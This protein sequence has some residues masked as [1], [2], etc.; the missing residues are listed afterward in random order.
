M[1][2]HWLI[3]WRNLT[4]RPGRSLAVAAG[5]MIGVALYMTVHMI[6]WGID[7]KAVQLN[8]GEYGEAAAAVLSGLR[9]GDGPGTVPPAVLEHVQGQAGVR[10][11]APRI[12]VHGHAAVVGGLADV[13]VA[14]ADL[15]KEMQLGNLRLTSGRLPE[16]GE[17]AVTVP[18][19]MKYGVKV[20]DGLPIILNGGRRV[21]AL[22]TGVVSDEGLGVINQGSVVV[23]HLN[24]A[25]AW[26]LGDRPTEVVVASETAA[27]RS[28][29]FEQLAL[30]L[31]KQV[32]VRLPVPSTRYWGAAFSQLMGLV[33]GLGLLVGGV[34]TYNA[35]ALTW[36]QRRQ[37][38]ALV[39]AVG[40]TPR[41]VTVQLAL[42]ALLLG[43]FASIPGVGAG[44]LLGKAALYTWVSRI[45]SM[46]LVLETLPFPWRGMV[47]ALL[48]GAVT[49]MLSG[50]V[51]ALNLSR[52]SVVSALTGGPEAQTSFAKSSVYGLAAALLGLAGAVRLPAP[53]SALCVI[54]FLLGLIPGFATMVPVV[55]G[56]ARRLSPLR[57]GAPAWIALRNLER[58]PRQAAN[59]GAALMAAIS[60]VVAYSGITHSV[61][62]A[63]DGQVRRLAGVHLVLTGDLPPTTIQTIRQMPGVGR[64]L[65]LSSLQVGANGEGGLTALAIDPVEQA[66]V[67]PM[68][69]TAGDSNSALEAM[70]RGEG[71]LVSSSRASRVGWR[72]GD[73][74]RLLGAKTGDTPITLPIVGIVQATWDESADL[75]LPSLVA[76]QLGDPLPSLGYVQLS[77]H[78][79]LTRVR[80]EIEQQ[81]PLLRVQ[82][83]QEY[84]GA[85]L[86][87]LRTDWK[88]FQAILSVVVLMA[89]FGVM[90]TL[91]SMVL[92]QQREFAL[93]QVVGATPRQVRRLVLGEALLLGLLATAAGIAAG[94]ILIY[95]FVHI[96]GEV[97]LQVVLAYPWAFAGYVLLLGPGLAVLTSLF[98]VRAATS[99][100]PVVELAQP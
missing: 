47:T 60:L 8:R 4:Q 72:L 5:V 25:S 12:R 10:L 31:D 77:D 100:N 91:L 37:D 69:L 39:L 62:T 93:L 21:T 92:E 94:S 55:L 99:A 75:W 82:S 19:A 65:A 26:Q 95:A 52:T 24:S 13:T 17:V 59:A 63:T 2:A 89:A 78:G 40:A 22:V 83:Y 76:E 49:A 33:R 56:V 27:G 71:V 68:L 58:D 57:T 43:T 9:G 32:D 88:P 15:D 14:L 85:Q 46:P 54:L 28:A 51:P 53:F 35:L 36:R 44:Y 45:G 90:S 30:T 66:K 67:A 16:S 20:G 97:G 98:A 1:T 87:R 84:R 70:A 80:G 3:T 48:L 38:T 73:P 11:V 7:V 29:L 23:A 96:S 42:E 86:D 81:F 64:V 6:V 34:L 18:F 79:A 41:Q 61:W 74:L 50:L